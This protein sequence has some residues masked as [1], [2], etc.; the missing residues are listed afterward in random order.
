MANTQDLPVK[1]EESAKTE[2]LSPGS[3]SCSGIHWELHIL[4][5]SSESRQQTDRHITTPQNYLPIPAFHREASD[6]LLSQR[7]YQ[8]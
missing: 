3:R 2:D 1:G 7:L 8:L 4:C 5:G 6:L